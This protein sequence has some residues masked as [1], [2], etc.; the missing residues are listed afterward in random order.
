MTRK[1]Y[2]LI[3]QIIR[4][5]ATTATERRYWAQVFAAKLADTNP[6]FDP[7][8]FIRAALLG[9]PKAKAAE[10]CDDCDCGGYDCRNRAAP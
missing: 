4:E 8:R 6:Q 7:R 5:N 2:V 10:I 1:D 9:P 3:A